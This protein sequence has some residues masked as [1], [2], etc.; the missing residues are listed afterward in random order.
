MC[1]SGQ[2]VRSSSPVIN[3]IFVAASGQ[4]ARA[5]CCRLCCASPDG[6]GTR[7]GER[8][9]LCWRIARDDGLDASGCGRHDGGEYGKLSCV[10][11]W[12]GLYRRSVHGL[13]KRAAGANLGP[14][15]KD[16]PR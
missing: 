7:P 9:H 4:I 1:R 13:E 14:T 10:G 6:R 16:R 5:G 2:G 15:S 11:T 8:C 12:I 3:A